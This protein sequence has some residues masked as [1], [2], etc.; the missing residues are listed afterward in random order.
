MLFANVRRENWRQALVSY[1]RSLP[2]LTATTNGIFQE[3]AQVTWREAQ[4]GVAR[5]EQ[6]LDK[7]SAS[8]R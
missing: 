3:I 8:R 2:E 1:Q 4:G 5:R 6:E 7:L